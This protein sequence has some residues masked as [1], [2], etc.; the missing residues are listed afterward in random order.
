MVSEKDKR[1]LTLVQTLQ[2]PELLLKVQHDTFINTHIN[3][4]CYNLLTK[5]IQLRGFPETL[6]CRRGVFT[7]EPHPS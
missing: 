2:S 6:F 1:K 3:K 7:L 5:M 4:I